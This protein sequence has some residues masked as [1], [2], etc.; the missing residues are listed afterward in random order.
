MSIDA[1]Y[2]KKRVLTLETYNFP[3]N[4]ILDWPL[5]PPIA[6]TYV[7]HIMRTSAK[8]MIL[9]HEIYGLFLSLL[10]LYAFVKFSRFY[11]VS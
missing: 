5:F 7:K 1:N 10:K 6:Y 8:T 3:Q 9:N 11:K 2:L 4:I